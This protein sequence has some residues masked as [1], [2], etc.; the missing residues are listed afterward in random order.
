MKDEE[1]PLGDE[2]RVVEDEDGSFDISTKLNYDQFYEL[3]KTIRS[4]KWM[5]DFV[6]CNIKMLWLRIRSSIEMLWIRL[7]VV[8]RLRFIGWGL[9]HQK[10]TIF[11]VLKVREEEMFWE[12][13]SILLYLC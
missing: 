2:E 13:L 7:A 6:G 5:S 4:K 1:V 12:Y 11:V 3:Y 8:L 9:P 10:S